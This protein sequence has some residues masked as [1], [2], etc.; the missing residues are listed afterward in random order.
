MQTPSSKPLT[1]TIPSNTFHSHRRLVSSITGTVFVRVTTTSWA[2]PKPTSVQS[3]ESRTLDPV[4][5]F[6][7]L[8]SKRHITIIMEGILWRDFQTMSIEQVTNV[9]IFQ[10]GLDSYV[11]KRSRTFCWR[12]AEYLRFRYNNLL[13]GL[14]IFKNTMSTFS[15]ASDF[16]SSKWF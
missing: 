12:N 9:V 13:N 10:V 15:S 6:G 8:N 14:S 3:R 4:V 16:I 1:M 2:P 7:V 5:H 11:D